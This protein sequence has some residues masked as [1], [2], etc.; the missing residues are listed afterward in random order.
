MHFH[1][2]II[3]FCALPDGS[4]V[5]CYERWIEKLKR[6]IFLLLEFLSACSGVSIKLFFILYRVTDVT[7]HK[8]YYATPLCVLVRN[9]C[10]NKNGPRKVGGEVLKEVTPSKQETDVIFISGSNRELKISSNIWE[11]DQPEISKEKTVVWDI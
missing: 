6:L 1:L 7:E 4:A 9:L 10:A 11:N 3:S 2:G 5:F 8:V